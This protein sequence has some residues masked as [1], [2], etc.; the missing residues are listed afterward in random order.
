MEVERMERARECER[1]REMERERGYPGEVE[2][3]GEER[4]GEQCSAAHSVAQRRE[5][6][7]TERIN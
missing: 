6:R 1:E 7:S 3:R 2:K 5:E 4:R